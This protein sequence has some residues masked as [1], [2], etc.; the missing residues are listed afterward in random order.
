[1]DDN[2]QFEGFKNIG[3]LVAIILMFVDIYYHYYKVFY[4]YG[5]HAPMGDSF[6]NAFIKMGIF[7]EMYYV[8]TFVIILSVL[9]V[10]LDS[11]RKNID[12][13]R[14][15][16]IYFAVF[17]TALYLATCLLPGITN[18]YFYLLI[19]IISFALLINS[20]NKLH[21]L[22]DTL[23]AKD[24]Y[25]KVNKVFPQNTELLENE[26]SVNIPFKFIKGYKKNLEPIYEDGI[27]NFV[28][29]ERATL[30]LGKPG[31]GKSYSFN[32]EFIRQW[33]EKGFAFINYDYKFPTLT[34]IAYFYF[35]KNKESAYGKY[36]NGGRFA[37]I[38]IS[39]PEYSD[40]CNPISVEIL[41]NMA[42]AIDAVYTIFYNLDKKSA[43][44]QDFFQ[45]SAMAITSAALWFLRQYD[46]GKYCTFPHLIQLIMQPDE[47]LLPILD[48]YPE[49]QYFTASFSDALAKE[50]FD[51]LS[52]QTASAR[53]PLGKCATPQMFWVMTDPDKT[54]V[55]LRVNEKDEVT[56]LNIA[57]DPATQKTN[58]PAIGLYLSQAAKLVNA[59]GRIPC[60]FHVDEFPT[61]YINGL[62]TLIATARSNKVCTVLSAQDYT[63]L[64]LN[65]GKEPADAI[66]N[67]I[68]NIVSGKV[69][70]DT[71][72][73]IS[74]GIGKFNYTTQSVSVQKDSNSTSFNTQREFIV[75]AEDISQFKQGEFCG[76]VSDSYKQP[77]DLKSFRGIVNPPKDDMTG[78]H[79]PKVRTVTNE[80]LKEN[81]KLIQDQVKE[82]IEN[83]LQR[84]QEEDNI[85]E[86]TND[87]KALQ[88]VNDV[89][90][91]NSFNT[92]LSFSQQNEE[93][94]P[95]ESNHEETSDNLD[96]T[97]VDNNQ[98]EDIEVP[99]QE[100]IP[101]ITDYSEYDIEQEIKKFEAENNFTVQDEID[102]LSLEE[103]NTIK[104]TATELLSEIMALES[105]TSNSDTEE[106]VNTRT[107]DRKQN[108]SVLKEGFGQQ[109]ID[110]T[111][112][113]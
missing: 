10:M 112:K 92:E 46:G 110:I 23:F 94:D 100:E 84:M 15:T 50:S 68:D 11:G 75:P 98:T 21:R 108:Q 80:D 35:Q 106:D 18:L 78:V 88:E 103:N 96:Y 22:F 41:Q 83:E 6:L 3:M 61:T 54:G 87:Q 70:I 101:D 53:I 72:K 104:K 42:D 74:E 90:Q 40:R 95:R 5:W 91:G 2:K 39:N 57:N 30:V 34:D 73:K 13:D 27:I 1:M 43:Q 33:I 111:K 20:Y 8:K 26:M 17:S 64:V 89:L 19:N 12:A 97:F 14:T 47:K 62:D 85:R 77:I 59:Q 93:H 31:S 86:N 16:T 82:I 67:T 66:Y 44:K 38:N 99:T 7:N 63:Q 79:F 109:S 51:Q 69:A 36:T 48:S 102:N 107:S 24:R 58:A 76:I 37:C 55:N 52:G 9:F 56:V 28:A 60:A 25:N 65:Y 45:M 32:E 105:F 49:L 29:P 81:M 113:E 4:G 71:A